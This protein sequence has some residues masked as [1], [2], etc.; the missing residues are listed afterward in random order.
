MAKRVW[1]SFVVDQKAL[2][3][4]IRTVEGANAGYTVF[5]E[6]S[7]ED[8]AEILN[9]LRQAKACCSVCQKPW[10]GDPDKCEYC[11]AEA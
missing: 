3:G 2:D 11:G 1:V 5:T 6:F 10:A 7:S 9:N 4:F 8:Q